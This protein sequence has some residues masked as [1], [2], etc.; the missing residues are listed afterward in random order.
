M[1]TTLTEQEAETLIRLLK[2]S[3]VDTIDF[4][5]KGSKKS[6]TVRGLKSNDLFDIHIFRSR[7]VVGKTNYDAIVIKDN[8][9]LLSLHIGGTLSHKNPDGSKLVGPHWHIYRENYDLLYAYP[10]TD[11]HNED[12]EQ[13]TLK[14]F[15]E[16]HIVEKPVVNYQQE[17]DL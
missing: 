11:V 16:F 8:V 3:L 10:A 2:K 17:L 14:F 1:S 6:F 4:P 7:T 12:F 13:N 15:E 9:R 5:S